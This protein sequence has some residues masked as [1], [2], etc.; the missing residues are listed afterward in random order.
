[1]TSAAVNRASGTSRDSP[2]NFNPVSGTRADG[3]HLGSVTGDHPRRPTMH[4]ETARRHVQPYDS[5]DASLVFS[6][7]PL[8]NLSATARRR[9]S[10]LASLA[11]LSDQAAAATAARAGPRP[12]YTANPELFPGSNP[13][14][15]RRNH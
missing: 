10:S 6:R 7:A 5:R 8:S 12:A 9:T 14:A 2:R 1:M 4:H 11:C 13:G 3:F 15:A